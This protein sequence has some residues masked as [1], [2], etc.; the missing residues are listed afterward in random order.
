MHRIAEASRSR[1]A[2]S[3]A[4][5]L[6]AACEGIDPSAVESEPDPE[7][8]APVD[9][10]EGSV[11]GRADFAPGNTASGGQGQEV[12]GVGCIEN[13]TLHYHAH[14]SLFAEG[15]RV[16]IP[17]AIGIVD[18]VIQGGF[19]RGGACFY[20][21]HTHDAAGLIHVEPPE[22]GEYTLGQLFDVWGQSL[23]RTTVA[24]L[25]GTLSVFVDGARYEGDVR[26]IV[27][28]SRKHIS[29]QVGRPLAPAPMY[30]F[31]G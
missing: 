20:W 13:V 6:L 22:A 18:P 15:E 9:L 7:P 12:N 8:A 16:A 29:L 28:T 2:L 24:G 11:L 26:S 1:A 5:L 21:L 10:V 14:L 19:V 23:S 27:L 3:G 31:Q 25:G 4:L 17:L 30:V